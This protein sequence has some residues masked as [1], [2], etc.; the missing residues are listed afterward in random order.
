[1][2]FTPLAFFTFYQGYRTIFINSKNQKILYTILQLSS[3]FLWICFAIIDLGAFNG[4]VRVSKLV[5]RDEGAAMFGLFLG[6]VESLMYITA[7]LLGFYSAWTLNSHQNNFD[8]I[9]AQENIKSDS[10]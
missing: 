1:M 9:E 2:I 8:D 10:K 5:K 7:S 3:C 4:V 6:V